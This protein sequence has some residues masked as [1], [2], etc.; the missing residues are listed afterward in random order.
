MATL[1]VLFD[2]ER[3]DVMGRLPGFQTLRC[4]SFLELPW[5]LSQLPAIWYRFLSSVSHT[6][7]LKFAYKLKVS[8][9]ACCPNGF[10]CSA[11]PSSPI[12]CS[13]HLQVVSM[14]LLTRALSR[15]WR[16][17]AAT[18]RTSL[19]AD[20]IDTM[21]AVKSHFDWFVTVNWSFAYMWLRT[22]VCV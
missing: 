7:A 18:L 22:P 9:S 16:T 13:F 20:S 17:H 14:S 10:W 1:G 5:L 6:K 12:T 15:R 3:E 19:A 2:V 11:V 8:L 4:E 21:S